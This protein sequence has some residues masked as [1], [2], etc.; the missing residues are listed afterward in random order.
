VVA[1]GARERRSL[2]EGES[3]KKRRESELATLSTL[4]DKK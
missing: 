4:F 1:P 2:L 3:E